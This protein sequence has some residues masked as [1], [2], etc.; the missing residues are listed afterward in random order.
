MIWF[1]VKLERKLKCDVCDD[2]FPTKLVLREHMN[3]FHRK[4]ERKLKCDV[5]DN[6]FPT[7]IN[8]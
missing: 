8:C 2:S 6:S 5:C 1:H 3:L 4:L 7:F